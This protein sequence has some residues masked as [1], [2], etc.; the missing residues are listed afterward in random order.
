MPRV[1]INKH[2]SVVQIEAAAKAWME[3]QFSNMTWEM[4][5]AKMRSRFIEGAIVILT[6]TVTAR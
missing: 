6:A 1:D 5:T 2:F 4:A 3:W